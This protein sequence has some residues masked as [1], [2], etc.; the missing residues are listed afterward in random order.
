MEDIKYEVQLHLTNLN[1]EEYKAIISEIAKH[2][3]IKSFGGGIDDF[4]QRKKRFFSLVKS[5]LTG[6]IFN[7]EELDDLIEKWKNEI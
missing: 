7:I 4:I 5:D 3:N 1:S 6:K 2:K